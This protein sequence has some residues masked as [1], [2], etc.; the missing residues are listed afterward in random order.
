M[1]PALA[2]PLAAALRGEPTRLGEVLRAVRA[3]ERDAEGS[4]GTGS[5]LAGIAPDVVA[6]VAA[7]HLAALAWT[8]R[9]RTWSTARVRSRCR[10][11]RPGRAGCAGRRSPAAG[12]AS[13]ASP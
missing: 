10:R 2:P 6:R 7:A 11:P 5:G 8:G 12:R 13:P 9:G 3:Y 4:W 1:L